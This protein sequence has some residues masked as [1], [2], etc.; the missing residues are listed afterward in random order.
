MILDDGDYWW[1]WLMILDDPGWLL[2][3]DT[4]DT[5]CYYWLILLVGI[6]WY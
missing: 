3:G 5:G 4:G 1:Y 2:A 6:A